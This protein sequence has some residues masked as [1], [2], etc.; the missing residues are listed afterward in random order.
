MLC[1]LAMRDT[2]CLCWRDGCLVAYS[3]LFVTWNKQSRRGLR[4]RGCIGTL[5]PRWLHAALRDYALTRYCTLSYL[6]RLDDPFL[7]LKTGDVFFSTLPC[8][9]LVQSMP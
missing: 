8:P 3:P 4:L 2:T 9:S 6:I 7:I 1:S 5:E